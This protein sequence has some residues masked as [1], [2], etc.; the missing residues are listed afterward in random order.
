MGRLR[1]AR[2]AR[3]WGGVQCGERQGGEGDG[4]RRL[5]VAAE[6]V[7]QAVDQDITQPDASSAG[8]APSD[9]PACAQVP[10][11]DSEVRREVREPAYAAVAN[12]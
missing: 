9:R 8:T 3:A 4:A 5:A 12:D 2:L 10:G 1:G 6:D 11:S 7:L